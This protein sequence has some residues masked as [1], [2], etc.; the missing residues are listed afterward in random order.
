MNRVT[1]FLHPVVATQALLAY[2]SLMQQPGFQRRSCLLSLNFPVTL[3]DPLGQT[4]QVGADK[5]SCERC[6]A[7][8]YVKQEGPA[9]VVRCFQTCL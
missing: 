1:A 8:Q 7:G 5:R 4:E 6:P 3:V 9:M 2:L